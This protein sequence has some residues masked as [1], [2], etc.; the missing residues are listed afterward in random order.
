MII[1]QLLGKEDLT[2]IYNYK[3]IQ[4]QYSF[5]KP[6]TIANV[7][8]FVKY[9]SSRAKRGFDKSNKEADILWLIIMMI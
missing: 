5:K 2:H 3:T 4:Y 1:P 6:E 9:F 7:K 8:E